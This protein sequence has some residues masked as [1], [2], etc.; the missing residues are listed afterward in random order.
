METARGSR[1]VDLFATADTPRR[2]PLPHPTRSKS[3][4]LSTGHIIANKE[5]RRLQ[6]KSSSHFDRERNA[7]AGR[8]EPGYV[9]PEADPETRAA[10]REKYAEERRRDRRTMIFATVLGLVTPVLIYYLLGWLQTLY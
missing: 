9:V 5:N 6:K 7:P 10:L 8:R 1:E 2:D 4:S 3:M